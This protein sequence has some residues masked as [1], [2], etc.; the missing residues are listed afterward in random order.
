MKARKT[1][2]KRAGALF[3]ALIFVLVGGAQAAQAEDVKGEATILEPDNIKGPIQFDDEPVIR[4]F[5]VID[6][7]IH[8]FW[9][10]ID[11]NREINL[12]D[13]IEGGRI[14]FST[15]LGSKDTLGPNVAPVDNILKQGGTDFSLLMTEGKDALESLGYEIVGE[16]PEGSHF[17]DFSGEVLGIQATG[18][19]N[20][21]GIVDFTSTLTYAEG[22]K[23][24]LPMQLKILPKF[25]ITKDFQVIGDATHPAL[26]FTFT[27]KPENGAPELNLDP[28]KLSYKDSEKGLKTSND[29][30]T[31]IEKKQPFTASGEYTYTL[32]ETETSYTQH[33]GEDYVDHLVTS[34]AKYE[35]TFVVESNPK[36]EG[37]RILS[38]RV[39][40]MA[41]DDGTVANGEKQENYYK[42][43]EDNGIRFANEY[44]KEVKEN[45]DKPLEKRG[46][47]VSKTVT[48]DLGD[49]NVYFPFSIELKAPE[50]IHVVDG[51][52]GEPATLTT[53]ARIYNSRTLKYETD[54][55]ANGITAD[56]NGYFE[57]TYGTAFTVQL[58]HGQ[59]L[60]FEKA[61][62]GSELTATETDPKGHTLSYQSVSGGGA[63]TNANTVMV[64]DQGI[65]KV[66]AMN[67]KDQTSAPT[68][69]TTNNTSFM[70]MT[71]IGVAG[72]AVL[73]FVGLKKKKALR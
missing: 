4:P 15:K 63:A 18:I 59:A 31:E 34:K 33:D 24:I 50:N 36:A 57:V 26:D 37:Y 43:G 60:V 21:P 49:K 58:K 14:V 7:D 47:F 42:E 25:F 44:N 45:P 11:L 40:K 67:N 10:L 52:Q 12:A 55:T 30:I 1:W 16:K 70:A 28:I 3:L 53:R 29:I 68:G 56:A 6:S 72:L 9:V 64:S 54:L 69:L 46:L 39:K 61:I 27:F 35:V 51:A 23:M 13:H 5:A 65:N 38:V 32:T 20:K 62:V 2:I 19:S 66:E 22:G 8:T 48:G 17:Q 73:L 41:N 71:L